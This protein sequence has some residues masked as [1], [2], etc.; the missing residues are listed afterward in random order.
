MIAEIHLNIEDI[1]PS[2]V[3]CGERHLIDEIS[4][5]VTRNARRQ[6]ARKP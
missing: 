5:V 4:A 1:E 6:D 2:A 3:S